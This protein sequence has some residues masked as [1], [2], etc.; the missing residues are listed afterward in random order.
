M[1]TNLNSIYPNPLRSAQRA[2]RWMFAA[3][4]AIGGALVALLVTTVAMFAE[5]LLPHVVEFCLMVWHALA[6]QLAYRLMFLGLI[7]LTL[8]VIAF[9]VRLWWHARLTERHI[10]KL[11]LK[12]QILPVKLAGMLEQLALATYVDLVVA[13]QPFAFCYGWRKPRV[14][15]TTGLVES[16]DD[17]ELK[18]VLAHEKYHLAQRDP[19]KILVARAL[20]DA[21]VFVPFLKDLVEN[22][23]VLQEI[24][25]DQSALEAGA[26][27]EALASA[28]LKVFRSPIW[29]SLSVGAYTPFG[30]RVQYLA[31]PQ[32]R[33]VL[34]FSW[35]RAVISI[36]AGILLM[37]AVVHP[38]APMALGEALH[39]DCHQGAILDIRLFS[40]TH[41]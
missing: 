32:R 40:M 3:V 1:A 20:R 7:V 2:A 15:V 14:L 36:V 12:K 38:M 9:L 21:V 17:V 13:P 27:R 39:Q 29:G 23:L 28:L 26:T 25:A 5:T 37:V 4:L 24:A 41:V 6:V 22:F 8:S 11:L 30:E 33:F 16:L 35:V 34:R 10:Q 18:S 19:F 31:N